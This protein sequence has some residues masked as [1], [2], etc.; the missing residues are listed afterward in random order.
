[1]LAV[2]PVLKSQLKQQN[3]EICQFPRPKQT[4]C[5]TDYS[6]IIW[7]KEVHHDSPKFWQF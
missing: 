3:V 5:L 1:M 6:D 2:F 4:T 7:Q